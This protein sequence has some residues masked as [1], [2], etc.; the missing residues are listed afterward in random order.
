MPK[1]QTLSINDNDGQ[2]EAK[3]SS[4][5][6]TQPPKKANAETPVP[7]SSS[8]SALSSVA[9]LPSTELDVIKLIEAPSKDDKQNTDSKK[10]T[11]AFVSVFVRDYKY[12]NDQ[13][14]D[15]EK[16][17]MSL[18]N[19]LKKALVAN[20]LPAANQNDPSTSREERAFNLIKKAFADC[21]RTKSR[22]GKKLLG[23]FEGAIKDALIKAK[24]CLPAEKTYCLRDKV[25]D[26]IAEIDLGK[27]TTK[28]HFDFNWNYHG[29]YEVLEPRRKPWAEQV[30][31]IIYDE[32][33]RY[34]PEVARHPFLS[35]DQK[36]YD[37][38]EKVNTAADKLKYTFSWL[39]HDA[40]RLQKQ[41]STGQL[42][43]I[44]SAVNGVQEEVLYGVKAADGMMAI[45][46]ASYNEKRKR[47]TTP[48][49]DWL[50]ELII[51]VVSKAMKA[52]QNNEIGIN[53]RDEHG[54]LI[55]AEDLQSYLGQALVILNKVNTATQFAKQDD[56]KSLSL[57]DDWERVNA[58][59]SESGE[60]KEVQR[61][62][63]Q[64]PLAYRLQRSWSEFL[65][66]AEFGESAFNHLAYFLKINITGVKLGVVNTFDLFAGDHYE[67]ESI[68]AAQCY[69]IEDADQ[70][71][72][73]FMDY[74][75]AACHQLQ[76]CFINN[77][78]LVKQAELFRQG[79]IECLEEAHKVFSSDLKL[80]IMLD[81]QISL[82]KKSKN[83]WETVEEEFDE[84]TND[85]G[86]KDK[87]Q[88]A[89]AFRQRWL[90]FEY[91]SGT[92]ILNK[93]KGYLGQD[94][95]A[96]G[97]VRF[98][99][100]DK[101]DNTANFPAEIIA[102]LKALHAKF[103]TAQMSDEKAFNLILYCFEILKQVRLDHKNDKPGGTGKTCF[104]DGLLECLEKIYK[105][106]SSVVEENK[107]DSKGPLPFNLYNAIED[108]IAKLK[109]V[110]NEGYAALAQREQPYA[111][112][113]LQVIKNKLSEY[114]SNNP[115][116]SSIYAEDKGDVDVL[117][118]AF[119]GRLNYECTQAEKKPETV[120]LASLVTLAKEMLATVNA[121]HTKRPKKEGDY[122]KTKGLQEICLIEAADEVCGAIWDEKIGLN[123]RDA[124]GQL[125]DKPIA[126][127][128]ILYDI[129]VGFSRV[130]RQNEY[131][132]AWEAHHKKYPPVTPGF[133][134]IYMSQR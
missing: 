9:P 134:V 56:E 80:N 57:L 3:S 55:K 132:K 90:K 115:S 6:V 124:K 7:P 88:F 98:S 85:T 97:L 4:V 84:K 40:G 11:D 94:L 47:S 45:L 60:F 37:R 113:V 46:D 86:N 100:H 64:S 73:F 65:K 131:A 116:S 123:P 14:S 24:E 72:L 130:N 127:K 54:K 89:N 69:T 41:D 121:I 74:C 117:F 53:L 23:N 38:V 44:F 110:K 76:T 91:E 118:N 107:A 77:P 83:D 75:F 92:E 61:L 30:M 103:S 19:G 51:K 34:R 2:E 125:L 58:V 67:F 52:I 102:K 112:Q 50:D 126:E 104:E 96:E 111:L 68:Y 93:L 39:L 17:L 101:K 119:R 120:T 62:E 32:F 25:E 79:L 5:V 21:E 78:L 29:G 33:K 18:F 8:S 114:K 108:L 10:T 15:L 26:L 105:Y 16:S 133:G 27:S 42:K 71:I 13:S 95:S 31:T 70:L 66:K 59:S 129:Y 82:V 122:P 43:I 1:L 106:R 49:K 99:F 22:Y 12:K 35:W 20:D 28:G 109:I 128:G 48:K 63:Q 81:D 36:E 87:S